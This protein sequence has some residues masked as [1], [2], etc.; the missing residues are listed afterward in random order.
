ML[1]IP[2]C[3]NYICRYTDLSLG[4]VIYINTGIL[5]CSRKYVF[6]HICVATYSVSLQCGSGVPCDVF[7]VAMC[8]N[9]IKAVRE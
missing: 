3:S 9:S 2:G 7:I 1:A 5:N 4:Y 6:C 8:E